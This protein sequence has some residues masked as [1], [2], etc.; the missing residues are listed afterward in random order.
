M[1]LLPEIVSLTT[2]E[3]LSTIYVSLPA[4][5]I[6]VSTPAPPSKVSLPS[7][8]IKVLIPELP[9]KELARVLPVPLM[10]VVPVRVRFSK[11]VPNV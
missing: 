5:P 11:F 2:S 6:K 7:P 3:V 1:P 8:P 10:D 4:P 9:I